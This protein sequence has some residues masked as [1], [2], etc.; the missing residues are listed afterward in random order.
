MS[1]GAAYVLV[2]SGFVFISEVFFPCKPVR[3]SI[4]DEPGV[5]YCVNPDD[6]RNEQG[7]LDYEKLNAFIESK[8]KK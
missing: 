8:K 3:I 2:F 7:F 1:V 5:L 4:N 6:L